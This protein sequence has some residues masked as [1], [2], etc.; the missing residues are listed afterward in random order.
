VIERTAVI[1]E[2][3]DRRAAAAGATRRRLAWRALLDACR[4]R[5]WPKN[6]LVAAAPAAAGV[7]DVS[8]TLARVVL[9]FAA[10]CLLS[11]ATYIV[12][13]LA[14][15]EQDRAH[16]MKRRRPIAAGALAPGP[17]LAAAAVLALSGLALAAAAR[18]LLAVFAAGYLALTL[19]YSLMWRNIAI[20]D[21]AA[22][23]GG[24]LLRAVAGGVAAHVRVSAA[25]VIVVSL[26]AILVV[27]GKRQA[28][29]RAANGH[30]AVLRPALS[31]YSVAALRRL[32]ALAC[33]A[34]IVTY[35]VWAFTRPEPSGVPL[36]A[37]TIPPFTAWLL[38]YTGLLAQGAGQAPEDLVLGDRL[39][40]GFGASWLVL[41]ALSVYVGH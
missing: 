36:H 3:T 33:A 29:L 27:A 6:G 28:E 30:L 21:I 2:P 26:G 7:L 39:L 35:C 15:R 41:F 8:A 37:L 13:D 23:A 11:S 16:P 24:F 19:S 32:I 31:G 38:R 17:A 40:L 14:D 25:F 22:I 1:D 4:P 34:A 9:A 12:N 5:Q 20:A 18:P 10:F